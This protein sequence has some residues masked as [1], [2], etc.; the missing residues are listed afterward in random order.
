MEGVC[1]EMQGVRGEDD[2]GEV[3]VTLNAMLVATSTLA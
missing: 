2:R 3:Q 1:P